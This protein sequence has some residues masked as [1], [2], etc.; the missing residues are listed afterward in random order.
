MDYEN[1]TL[2]GKLVFVLF[3]FVLS[4]FCTVAGYWLFLLCHWLVA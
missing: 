1:K 2:K 3:V 4:L